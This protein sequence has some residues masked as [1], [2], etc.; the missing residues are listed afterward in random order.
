MDLKWPTL[1]SKILFDQTMILD[2]YTLDP[3]F[4]TIFGANHKVPVPIG[5]L[6]MRGFQN[7]PDF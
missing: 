1:F 7:T 4:S 6:M 2:P 5:K 3:I